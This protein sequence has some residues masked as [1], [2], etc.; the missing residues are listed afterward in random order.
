MMHFCD[1]TYRQCRGEWKLAR[2]Y[3][4]SCPSGFL[5]CM[6]GGRPSSRPY[7]YA[8]HRAMMHFCDHTYRQCR[9]EWKLAR[10][11]VV[12]C[13]SG[14]LHCMCG[15]RPSSRPYSYAIHR[16]S[17]CAVIAIRYR[18]TANT[19]MCTPNIAG[20]ARVYAKKAWLPDRQPRSNYLLRKD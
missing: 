20:M 5:H 19:A 1:H 15:G 6:C 12:S 7:S 11:Y 16:A 3:V 2:V 13:P 14:F 17:G 4:V 9:G 8:I 10:V 18:M